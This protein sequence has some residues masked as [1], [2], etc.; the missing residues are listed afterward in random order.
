MFD[1]LN[2]KPMAFGLDISDLSIKIIQLKKRGRFF[3]LVSWGET[4][5]QPGVIENGEIKNENKFLELLKQAI[6]DVKGKKIKIKNAVVSLPEKK[7]FL[8]IV[9]LPMMKKEELRSAITFQAENY[10]PLSINEVY[11]DFQIIPLDSKIQDRCDVLLVAFPKKIIDQYLAILR[12]AGIS[13]IAFE[14]E[15]QAI[16]R[17]LSKNNAENFSFF[18]IDF[19]ES[20]TIFAT[21]SDHSLHFSSS[22]PISSQDLTKA[23]SQSFNVNL[24]E[25]EKLK[26][27]YGLAL[28][29]NSEKEEEVSKTIEP[30]LNDLCEQVKKYV[31]YYRAYGYP[32]Y[33]DADKKNAK[34]K[35]IEKIILCGK[36]ANLKGLSDFFSSKLEI[37]VKLANPW[38]NVFKKEAVG[39]PLKESLGY[40]TALGLALRGA[41]KNSE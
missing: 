37:P 3:K 32:E 5:I 18:V 34:S 19:G 40:V 39:L 15:S 41:E 28:S 24:E 22:I 27:K 7:V 6:K 10:I 26:L 30:I 12:K 35:K 1:S 14:N 13:P 4:Q 21:F 31:S 11:L 9:Q 33:P 25:A 36:G 20:N 16:T 38:L 2:T 29:Q 8:E 17:V 23:I